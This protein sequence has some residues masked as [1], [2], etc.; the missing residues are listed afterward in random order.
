MRYFL[1]AINV[2]MADNDFTKAVESKA[3]TMKT[4]VKKEYNNQ[5]TLLFL[6]ML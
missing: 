1:T 6:S 2:N 4:A 3:V 5:S